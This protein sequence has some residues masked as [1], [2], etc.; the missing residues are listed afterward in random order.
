MKKVSSKDLSVDI[1][2]ISSLSLERQNKGNDSVYITDLPDCDT[3]D[4][5]VNT[6]GEGCGA[7][8]FASDCVCTKEKCGSNECQSVDCTKSAG[9][10]CCDYSKDDCVVPYTVGD[11]DTVIIQ[12][13]ERCGT[14]LDSLCPYSVDSPCILSENLDE[15]PGRMTVDDNC[16]IL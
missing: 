6:E 13:S 8:T 16:D 3:K 9:E 2:P 7:N 10:V 15:C 5:C 4:T 12:T 11:C 14:S 1:K